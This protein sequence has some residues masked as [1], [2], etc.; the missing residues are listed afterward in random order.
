MSLLLHSLNMFIVDLKSHSLGKT[1]SPEV[2]PTK[3]NM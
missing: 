3:A 2:K 1:L